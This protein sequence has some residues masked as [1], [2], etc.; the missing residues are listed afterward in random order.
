MNALNEVILTLD[1]DWAPDC[2]IDFVAD[3]LITKNVRATW[4]LTHLSPAIE[5]LRHRPDLFELAIHPNFL[6]GSTHG[7]TPEEVLRFCLNMVP[8]AV[9]VRTHALVQSTPLLRAILFQTNIAVDSSLFLPLMSGIQPTEFRLNDR[10][11]S[12]IP[13]WWIDDYLLEQPRPSWNVRSLLAGTPGLR[14]FDFHPIHIYLNSSTPAEYRAL[15]NRVPRIQQAVAG[16]VDPH[17]RNGEGA[18]SAFLQ[19]IEMLHREG[20]SHRMRDIF[21]MW[22]SD[23]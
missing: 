10:A 5:R 11:L 21:D 1:V 6:P 20:R 14:V 2:A 12:R 19:V 13:F 16:D 18:R 3:C 23:G 4:F 15:K 17:V 9:S 7:E 22:K 8:D